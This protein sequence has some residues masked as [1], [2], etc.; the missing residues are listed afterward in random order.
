MDPSYYVFNLPDTKEGAE[1]I[2]MVPF[3][4]K[5]KQN[6]TAIMM[7]R[8]DGDNYGQLI[9]YTMPK[10][11]TI[12]GP[13]QI[14][15]QIDQNTEI[16]KE[17]SLWKQSGS[18]YK[19]GDLFVIPIGTSLLYV[20]PVYLEATNQAIPEVKRV[21][22]AY[23]D[24]IAYEATLGE[25]LMSLFGGDA[26]DSGSKI[27]GL[28]DG[29]TDEDLKSLIKKAQNAYDKA[30]ECQK[31]GDWEGYGKYIK[32]LESYLTKLVN[33]SGTSAPAAAPAEEPAQEEATDEAA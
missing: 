9:V 4:P 15:A 20:E 27:D 23:Q 10:N 25:A 24:K 7:G 6:M 12:Y 13:M 31:E 18:T 29:G 11:K 5:S 1:F 3:T 30:I 26:G 2:N 19:R 28:D 14:E 17:F 8:N 16:S 22:V 33:E 21:I 32:Q